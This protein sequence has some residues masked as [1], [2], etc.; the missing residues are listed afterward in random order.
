M[1]VEEKKLDASEAAVQPTS[2]NGEGEIEP[3][4]PQLSRALK[5]RHMQMIAIGGS[6]G[7]GLFVG[8]GGALRTGGPAALLI[9]FIIIGC[10]MMCTVQAL[11]ELAIIYP[12]NGAFY[13]YAVRFIDP[14]WGFAM[15]WEYSIGWMVTLPFEITA[16]GITIEFWKSREEVNPGVWCAV[17]MSLLIIIQVFGVR[18]Y[19]EV[20]FIL[21]IVKIIACIGF[22]ILGIIINAGGVPT[23]PRGYIGAQYWHDPG[24]FRNGFQG[25][26]SVFVTAAFSFGGTEMV[27]LAAAE[28]RNPRKTLPKA[29]RQ[30]FWRIALFYIL[31][32]FIMGLIVPSDSDVLLGASGANTKASPFVLAVQLA[33]IQVLPHIINGVITCA[34]IS[35]A[36]SCT[37]GSTRVLQAL[38]QSGRAP[39]IFAKI[40][41]SGRPIYCVALQVAFGFISFI[42]VAAD[43]KTVFN[44]LLAVTGL[45]GQFAYASIMIAHIRF[46]KAW[47][48]QGRSPE[49][50]PWRSALGV[51]GSHVGV[52]LVC[53]SLAATF[54]SSLFPVGGKPSA[55][56]FFQGYL[57]APITI[58]L[59]LFWKVYTKDWGFGVDL[60]SVDLD[61]GRRPEEELDD[62]YEGTEKKKTVWKRGLS[63]IF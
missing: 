57:A 59:F 4:H 21:A 3:Q 51:V 14:A 32:I 38:A 62:V 23:D 45:S 39:S 13:E 63:V 47:K 61:M 49:D 24:A 25:F 34:V 29:T 27:G 54:Y 5:G 8:T 50:I 19:G 40:D 20:E 18:G 58:S 46:R 11:G 22:I 37:Y 7:A 41:K 48:V 33:G 60:H 2:S 44:W 35:V 6:I 17:F 12:V 42:T 15:G 30:V 9:G 55:E 26:C 53:C 28:A 1:T 36:N 10:M 52:F 43:S 56:S 31:N 16:A